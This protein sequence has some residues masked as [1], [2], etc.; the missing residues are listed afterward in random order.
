LLDAS[1]VSAL[2]QIDGDLQ[3]LVEEVGWKCRIPPTLAAATKT[4]AGL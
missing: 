4:Q 1:E 3:V 2:D